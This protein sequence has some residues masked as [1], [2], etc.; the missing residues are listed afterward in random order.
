[1]KLVSLF[2]EFL[3]N[4]NNEMES[5]RFTDRLF[6]I[7][8]HRKKREEEGRC[9]CCAWTRMWEPRD[10]RIA[11]WFSRKPNCRKREVRSVGR[12]GEVRVHRG[13]R[14]GARGCTCNRASN[15]EGWL[16]GWLAPDLAK[17]RRNARLPGAVRERGFFWWAELRPLFDPTWNCDKR[18]RPTDLTSYDGA[19][20]REE[21]PCCARPG[22][23]LQL[24]SASALL[25]FE[26][27]FENTYGGIRT[28]S[29]DRGNELIVE[30][31]N[32]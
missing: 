11:H 26:K 24:Y 31:I 17:R 15:R 27:S 19:R 10:V 29:R 13:W 28:K 32:C 3:T 5:I 18:H 23:R 6:K 20:A 8:S 12:R 4:N 9:S 2:I 1:M 7:R 14:N 22:D 16:A 21:R 30:L 25:S